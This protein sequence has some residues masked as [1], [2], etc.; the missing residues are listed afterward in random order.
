MV[1]GID[2]YH[3]SEKTGR[4]KSKMSVLGMVSSFNPRV[5]LAQ[6]I[7]RFPFLAQNNLCPSSAA[8]KGCAGLLYV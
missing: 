6:I 8:R 4:D 1:V 3:D 2:V 5:S 7:S